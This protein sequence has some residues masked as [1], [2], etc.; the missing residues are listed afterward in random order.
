M[1]LISLLN[2]YCGRDLQASIKD[3]A[4]QRYLKIVRDQILA[5]MPS[6]V[7]LAVILLPALEQPSSTSQIFRII[8]ESL[9]FPFIHTPHNDTKYMDENNTLESHRRC[10]GDL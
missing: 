2:H 5:V 6:A 10:R 3:T 7:A 9:H 4:A 1:A 8:L